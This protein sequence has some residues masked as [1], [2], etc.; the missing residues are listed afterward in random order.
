MLVAVFAATAVLAAMTPAA[1]RQGGTTV[2][3]R[4]TL[5]PYAVTVVA[6]PG[7]PG[8]NRLTITLRGAA[9]APERIAAGARQRRLGLGP[10]R[11]RARRVAPGRFS[12]PDAS[13]PAPGAW[14]LTIAAAGSPPARLRCACARR[15]A[16]QCRCRT[17]FALAPPCSA[18]VAKRNRSDDRRNAWVPARGV[19]SRAVRARLRDKTS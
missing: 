1:E 11:L 18:I 8:D 2:T 13:L 12:V 14:E 9:P 16:S 3:A 6:R 7:R 15:V 4:G 5:G 19:V 10:V 17:R